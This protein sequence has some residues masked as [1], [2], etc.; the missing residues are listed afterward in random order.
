[1]F[2]NPELAARIREAGHSVG[3]HGYT[4][5]DLN[6]LAAEDATRDI[7]RG[8]EAVEKAAFGSAIERPRL[9]RFPGFKSTPELVEF[10]RSRHGIVVDRNIGSADW[11]GD[12]A[13][14]TFER[15]RQRL[16]RQDRGIIILH[17]N[18]PETAKLVP[19]LI[20]ELKARRMKIVHLMAE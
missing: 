16:D 5:R 13:Q 8:Y 18:Q 14:V 4:H 19:M 6:E 20:A 12:P 7:Q 11:R 1:M 3:S 17:D 10:V 15:L 9:F 2:G